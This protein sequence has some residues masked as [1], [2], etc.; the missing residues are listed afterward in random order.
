MTWSLVKLRDTFTFTYRQ[1]R[2]D[3][4]SPCLWSVSFLQDHN[5]IL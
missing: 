2:F 3:W 5:Q 1:N 4:Y